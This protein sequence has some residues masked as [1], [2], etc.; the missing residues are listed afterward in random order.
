[1]VLLATTACGGDLLGA[2]SDAGN[3]VP[4]VPV[5]DASPPP[6]HDAGSVETGLPDAVAIQ[7]GPVCGSESWSTVFADWVANSSG[8][9]FYGWVFD[10][11]ID[12]LRF[13]R[14]VAVNY[15]FVDPTTGMLCTAVDTCT[16]DPRTLRVSQQDVYHSNALGEFIGPDGKPYAWAYFPPLNRW[17][18][19]EGDRTPQGYRWIVE[20]NAGC[21]PDCPCDAG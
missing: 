16:Y 18:L 7:D 5:A 14:Q 6:S 12:F 8:S 2:P 1:M 17:F 10:R 3:D 9:Q 15:Q 13:V 20:Y 19:S 21:S 11:D 4:I